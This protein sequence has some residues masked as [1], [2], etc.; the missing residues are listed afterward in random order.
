M[1]F[2]TLKI[3]LSLLI[4]LLPIATKGNDPFSPLFD[5][6]CNEVQCGKGTCQAS[7]GYPFNFKCICESG[8]KRTHLDNED[9]LQ[10]MPCVIPNCSLDYSCMPA[11][12]PVPPVP[13][14]TSF[15]DPCYWIYCGEGTCVKNSTYTHI[16]QCNGGYSNLYNV[17][18]F[19]CFSECAIGS[20][21]SRLGVKVAKSTS[22]PN[23]DASP[24][25]STLPGKFQ[26]MGIFL[27]SGFVLLGKWEFEVSIL[28]VI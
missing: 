16:C 12:P 21:C 19:P 14:N 23:S 6:I 22:S 7:P 11:A 26:W 10:F 4:I 9:N 5:N 17:A 13:Y 27:I 24:A 25:K 20:D 2:S 1:A 18:A 3:S 15:F 28:D 8:W